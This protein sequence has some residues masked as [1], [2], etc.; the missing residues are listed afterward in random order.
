MN[1][2]SFYLSVILEAKPFEREIVRNLSTS[3][4][5]SLPS[6]KVLI[7][8]S[9]SYLGLACHLISLVNQRLFRWGKKKQIVK[10]LQVCTRA[11]GAHAKELSIRQAPKE[12][13]IPESTLRRYL[14]KV[15]K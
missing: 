9:H 5:Y 4:L 14:K 8:I 6:D 11:A 7:L 2:F 13:S 10:C 12:F 1:H 3:T 15:G